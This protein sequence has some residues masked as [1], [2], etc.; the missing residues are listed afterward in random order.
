M[1]M[2]NDQKK[3][4]YMLNEEPPFISSCITILFDLF[5][6]LLTICQYKSKRRNGK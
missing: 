4:E 1:I 3:K 5:I 2:N 6:I